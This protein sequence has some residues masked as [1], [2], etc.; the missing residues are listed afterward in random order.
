MYSGGGTYNYANVTTGNYD[1]GLYTHCMILGQIGDNIYIANRS[2]HG[3]QHYDNPSQNP[4]YIE[5]EDKD[6][7]LDYIPESWLLY[8]NDTIGT[9]RH[10]FCYSHDTL[11]SLGIEK[12]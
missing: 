7:I 11:V 9:A 10:I 6:A 1:Y 12:D 3:I 4:A 5:V 2:K 8:M